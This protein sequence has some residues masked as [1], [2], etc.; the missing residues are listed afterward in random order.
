MTAE[1][2]ETAN[3]SHN[4]NESYDLPE[5]GSNYL[6]NNTVFDMNSSLLLLAYSIQNIVSI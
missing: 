5:G 6:P 3:T 2:Q 4:N 1:H